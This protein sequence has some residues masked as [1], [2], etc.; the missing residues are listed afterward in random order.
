MKQSSF[1]FDEIIGIQEEIAKTILRD[2]SRFEHKQILPEN[3][4]VVQK[5]N[6]KF[7]ANKVVLK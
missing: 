3:N 4:A 6:E 1:T 7:Q 5:V 2:S